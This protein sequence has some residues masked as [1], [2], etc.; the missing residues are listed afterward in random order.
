MCKLNLFKKGISTKKHG[1]PSNS[2]PRN[3]YIPSLC[4]SPKKVYEVTAEETRFLDA[5]MSKSEHLITE[6]YRFE[7]LSNGT[8]NVWY[9]R[10]FVGKVK[11]QGRRTFFM[12]MKNIYDS[13]TI[14]DATLNDY[15]NSLDLWIKY[16]NRY[17]TKDI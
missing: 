7:R 17:L 14:E 9:R 5:L 2:T 15:I 16:I 11:L 3:Y 12:Y 4:S 10:Y 1:V 6:R 13:V 8:I